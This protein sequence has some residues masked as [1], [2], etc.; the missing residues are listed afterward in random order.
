MIKTFKRRVG[1]IGENVA[2]RFLRSKKFKILER[3]YLKKW[4]EIDIIAKKKKDIHF[5][6]VKTISRNLDV[7]DPVKSCSA[8]LSLTEFNGVN[9]KDNE[10]RAEE[11]VHPWKIKRLNRAIQ[12]YLEENNISDDIDWTLDLVVVYLD[13]ENKKAKVDFL[14]NIF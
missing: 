5:I 8:G 13:L 9:K 3:N 7:S 14:D 2:C 12:S 10:Y 6:E 4:G 1:D 11:N